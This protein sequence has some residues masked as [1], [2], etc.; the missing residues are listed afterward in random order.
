MDGRTGSGD[1]FHETLEDI[2]SASSSDAEEGGRR[3]MRARVARVAPATSHERPPVWTPSSFH[4]KFSV[5]KDDPSSVNDRRQRFFKNWGIKNLREE[6]SVGPA[7]TLVSKGLLS[8]GAAKGAQQVLDVSNGDASANSA[9]N[10]NISRHRD[11]TSTSGSETTE[12]EKR[13][14]CNTLENG[15]KSSTDV[16]QLESPGTVI[17]GNNRLEET[18]GAVLREGKN[19][20]APVL[21]RLGPVT[22][23]TGGEGGHGKH[24]S[25]GYSSDASPYQERTDKVLASPEG[26]LSPLWNGSSPM[27]SGYL[28]QASSSQEKLS[29]YHQSDT[30][31]GY[32]TRSQDGYSAAEEYGMDDLGLKIRDLD[33][34]KEFLINRFNQDGSLNMLREVDTGRELTLAEFEK[35][36]GL[37]PITQEMKRR[38]RAAESAISNEKSG[39]GKTSSKKKN[40]WLKYFVVKKP[41]EK[42]V[43]GGSARSDKHSQSGE[44]TDGSSKGARLSRDGSRDGSKGGNSRD[45]SFAG[46]DREEST[47]G[48]LPADDATG[49]T[50]RQP[51]KVKVKLRRKSIKEL[52]DLHMGQEIQGHQGAIWTMKFSPDGRYL[53][54]AGQ[55]R[56]VHVWEVLD[57]PSFS[58][59]D[60][61]GGQENGN[62]ANGL[63]LQGDGGS[64]KDSNVKA[65]PKGE[66]EGST[67]GVKDR[68]S[69]AD[70][71]GST[72]CA[73]EGSTRGAK[74]GST[75]GA[76]E[77]S[78]RGGKPL[79]QK[80]PSNP[81]SKGPLPKLFWLS[82]K[83]VRSFHGHTGDILD[84]SWSHS[85]L[86][87][88]SSMDK[89]V[90]LWHISYE[91][92]LRVFSHN[93]YVT[94]VQFNPVDDSYFLS[95]ALDDKL[96]IW[97]IAE[98]Q[99]VDWI[100]LRE[101]ITAVSYSPDGEKAIVGSYKGTC[102]FY[103]TTGNKLQF[104]NSIDVR[105]E[106]K[107]GRGKKITGIH[108]MPGDPQ[109]VLVT[110]NDSRL[111]VYD[112]QE[113]CAKYKGLKNINSQISASYTKNG[114][115][116]I[117]ASE[118]SR[119]LIWSSDNK[120]PSSAKSLYRR[121][122][123]LAC[124]EFNCRYVSV[125]VPWPEPTTD[126]S[127][128]LPNSATPAGSDGVDSA[129]AASEPDLS[130]PQNNAGALSIEN[131]DDDDDK[132][133]PSNE[134][135]ESARRDQVVLLDEEPDSVDQVENASLDANLENRDDSIDSSPRLHS[136]A[137]FFTDSGPKGSSTWPE[138]Q[139]PAFG[140]PL[141]SGP[142]LMRS[143][144]LGSDD[145]R[146][147]VEDAS[148]VKDTPPVAPLW[149]LV[150]V[151][152][153]LDGEIRTFQNYG[154]PVRL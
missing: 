110:S 39:T 38:Q 147:V 96:R 10:D 17:S 145:G 146:R 115:Y 25:S 70:K 4:S 152:A 89:T 31:N 43:S 141:S 85:K 112:D 149:G 9:E 153:G 69:E 74:E 21:S 144:S 79:S 61:S 5:W 82:E 106:N 6:P 22:A 98:H 94:C 104:E 100:D 53:A 50:W 63:H 77:G 64:A 15:C 7:T 117:S 102:R 154:Q 97:N 16:G 121:D 71:D 44:D 72:R 130:P 13:A 137:S 35:V 119:V 113:L 48:D 11:G 27:E 90:R 23:V 86:L 73:K 101:M 59:L 66:K 34:G 40:G 91:E 41:K 143:A 49:P 76:K 122:K 135:L 133:E 108:C 33:S 80:K 29:H 118:D 3:S 20:S 88:S 142:G 12:L 45:G 67:K 132:F 116:I 52:S 87:L 56:V 32:E 30:D 75:R 65:S 8:A 28:H 55:D 83:P 1:E 2:T 125:A 62:S 140:S 84:L 123:Q 93:D 138:E 131:S 47:K 128:L 129:R 136:C 81:E 92:C 60:L 99:V 19:K 78:T 126:S 127:T 103:N 107:K 114:D 58:E 151:T 57:H 111:R 139:L 26:S 14:D 42:P 134:F 51:K 109:K 124:E 46:P 105:T 120:D 18:S 54:S 36:V 24:R 95:G 148:P 37:S 68:S 150:I